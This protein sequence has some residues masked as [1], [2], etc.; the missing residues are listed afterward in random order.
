MVILR[1][2]SFEV[3]N[4]VAFIEDLIGV[5]YANPWYSVPFP[6]TQYLPDLFYE[7]YLVIRQAWLLEC[8]YFRFNRVVFFIYCCNV[9][10]TIYYISE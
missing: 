2:E 4:D 3:D 10:L 8:R 9:I 7:T 1:M 5:D 6:N